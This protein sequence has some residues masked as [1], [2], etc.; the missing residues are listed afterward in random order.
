MKDKVR[1][2]IKKKIFD[3]E[4]HIIQLKDLTKPI[5]PENAIGRVS[6]MEA[7]VNKSVNEVSL[8]K[9]EQMLNKLKLALKKVDEANFG[10][11]FRCGNIIPIERIMIVPESNTCVKCS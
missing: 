3:T 6:R 2:L 10:K 9:A 7:I 8:Y 5:A 4:K 11:C 1:L